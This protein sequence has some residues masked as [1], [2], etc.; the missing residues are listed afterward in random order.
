M[1]LTRN[2]CKGDEEIAG[3]FH[4]LLTVVDQQAQRI[5]R[6][7]KRVHEL[8]RR[9]GQNST[10]AASLLLAM[11]YVNR[12]IFAPPA[13]RREPPQAMKGRHFISWIIPMR[14]SSM[15]S[16]L[17]RDVEL[18]WMLWRAKPMRSAKFSTC[19][20]PVFGSPNIIQSGDFFLDVLPMLF[21]YRQS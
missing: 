18:R 20:H 3:Y 14:S 19:L 16:G 21:E 12:Q 6:L 2:I 8:E 13:A 11:V 4:A 5:E 7:E 17:V 15:G 1:K 9:L 10:I